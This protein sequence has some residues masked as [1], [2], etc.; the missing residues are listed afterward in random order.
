[1]SYP[2]PGTTRT[3]PS[4]YGGRRFFLVTGIL[5]VTVLIFVF[6][7]WQSDPSSQTEVPLKSPDALVVFAGHYGNKIPSVAA[8]YRRYG[9]GPR[10]FLT[11]DGVLSRWSRKYRRNLYNVEVAEEELVELGVPRSA[12]VK[13][14]FC[15]SG[16]IYD[17]LAAVSYISKA[18]FKKITLVSTDYH[19]RRAVWSFR[20]LLSSRDV[21]IGIY[22]IKSAQRIPGEAMREYI[23]LWY[24]RMAYS[25]STT[26]SLFKAGCG[27]T[28]SSPRPSP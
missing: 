22:P 26:D 21:E 9:D 28:P 15:R 14:P 12:I 1:V 11:D 16:T 25:F 4:G 3:A 8:L 13:L 5:L 20:R 24:Y 27:S 10:I 7:V 17:A 18:G 23:K 6:D 19:A 2:R